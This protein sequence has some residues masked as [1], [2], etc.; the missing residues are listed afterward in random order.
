ML[1]HREHKLPVTL[2]VALM[3]V[4]SACGSEAAEPSGELPFEPGAYPAA[5]PAECPSDEAG[6]ALPGFKRITS[7][8]ESTV[9]FELCSP[10]AAFLNKLAMISFNIQDS[11]YLATHGADGSIMREPNG[12]GPFAL[13]SW[14]D[15]TQIVLSRFDDYWGEK[16]N[17][18]SAVIQFQ[19]DSSARLVM[20]QAGTVDGTPVIGSSDEAAILADANLKL[21]RRPAITMAYI[22]MT[23]RAEPFNDVRVRRAIAL[24]VDRQRIVDLFYPEGSSTAHSFTPCEITFGCAG[25]EWYEPDPA[26]AQAL[27][28]EAGFPDGFETTIIV[29]SDVT[30]H[31]PYPMEIA[32]D[33]QA[34]LKLIGIEATIEVLERTT[35]TDRLISGEN[36]GIGI[37]GGWVADYAD[38]TNYLDFFFRA[39]QGGSARFGEP[40][41]DVSA[42]LVEAAQ[43]LDLK[44][45][46][47]IYAE[48][49]RLIKE[50]V[51][52]I[53]TVQTG[54]AIVYRA[55]VEG[56]NS[57]PLE[58]ENLAALKPGTRDTFVWVIPTEPGSLYCAAMGGQD[59][60]RVCNQIGE[61]LYG[62][63]LG[64][65]TLKPLLSTG[66]TASSDGLT[67]TCA[68]R[69]NVRFHNGSLFD[70]TDVRDTFAV[71]WDCAHPWRLKGGVF[72][73]I[74]LFTGVLNEAACSQE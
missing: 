8:N 3:L 51:P 25:P 40:Y 42:L 26:A 24:G 20:L 27:L 64:S 33:V 45:R 28:S 35:W 67:W 39:D 70:A 66:C 29:R 6:N 36:I 2:L 1:K 12:T 5:G 38:P 22:A 21:L 9:V 30:S 58:L 31:T 37:G 48:A 54:S 57:S 72:D 49:N 43:E 53:P 13:A 17:V 73:D 32:Q 10:D 47:G 69:E 46:E 71:M 74:T 41:A 14:Q 52:V 23:N 11:G 61:S 19:N 18:K 15:G 62:F 65:T 55:D 59:L 56:A 68:L 34:Q 7:M 16:A 60:L 50:N 63:E 4:L 44:R